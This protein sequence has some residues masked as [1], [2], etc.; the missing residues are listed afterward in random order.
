[1]GTE[2]RNGGG[3]IPRH[4]YG[5]YTAGEEQGSYNHG[6]G[7][8]AGGHA[9]RRGQQEWGACTVVPSLSLL[10]FHIIWKRNSGKGASPGGHGGWEVEGRDGRS[11]KM[12][13]EWF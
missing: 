5:P 13:K 6:G 3:C 4:G 9:R 10:V 7:S 8:V 2:R 12:G 11:S 1:M